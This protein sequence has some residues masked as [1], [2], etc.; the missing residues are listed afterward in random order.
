MR[1]HGESAGV[2]S[3]DRGMLGLSVA[4]RLLELQGGSFSMELVDEE[5]GRLV[6]EIPLQDG[7]QG[8]QTVA[9][10]EEEPLGVDLA[11]T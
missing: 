10:T 1:S 11:T 4:T 2:T 5:E 3:A 6:L 7:D 9:K 8:N